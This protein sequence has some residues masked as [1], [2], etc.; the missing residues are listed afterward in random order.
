MDF[1]KPEIVSDSGFG[2]DKLQVEFI[3]YQFF[4]SELSNK[5]VPIKDYQSINPITVPLLPKFQSVL[6]AIKRGARTV[7]VGVAGGA[8]VSAVVNNA[9][10][11]G[12]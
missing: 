10:N 4:K 12:M 3:D 1:K 8:I 11:T 7:S 9:L 5:T 6:K 2:P